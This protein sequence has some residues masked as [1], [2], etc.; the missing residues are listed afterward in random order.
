LA[1]LAAKQSWLN[2]G[3]EVFITDI[4]PDISFDGTQ[5]AIEYR[6]GSL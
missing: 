3:A 5:F 6:R 2:N 1:A 4:A